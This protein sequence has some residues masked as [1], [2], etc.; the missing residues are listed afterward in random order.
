MSP[1]PA[2]AAA[3]GYAVG[4]VPDEAPEAYLRYYCR[5]L[6]RQGS[7]APGA[8]MDYTIAPDVLRHRIGLSYEARG[9]GRDADAVLTDLVK[10]VAPA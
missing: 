9:Q 6:T 7:A 10:L 3:D 8:V 4:S 2:R 5:I 1:L